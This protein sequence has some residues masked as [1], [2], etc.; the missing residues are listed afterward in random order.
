MM[1]FLRR[2]GAIVG[3]RLVRAAWWIFRPVILGIRVVVR[4]DDEVL[5]VR[6]TYRPEWFLPGG[7]PKRG[8][9]LADTA[10]RE[11]REETGM[12]VDEV[13]LSGVYSSLFPSFSNHVVVFAATVRDQESETESP[14]IDAL[15]WAN[16]DDLPAA[17]ASETTAVIRRVR[18][19]DGAQ[20]VVVRD[21]ERGTKP[22]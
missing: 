17:C 14:E 4:R 10:R 5:L 2:L 16:P 7:Q 8:E 15:R 3:Y 11:V 6:H 20:Y 12:Y 1:G 13:S 19:A 9:S 22:A 18:T 21:G